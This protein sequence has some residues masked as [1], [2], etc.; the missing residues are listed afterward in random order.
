MTKRVHTL[1]IVLIKPMGRL[2]AR[3]EGSSFLCKRVVRDSFHVVGV[4]PVSQK[5]RKRCRREDLKEAGIRR[6]SSFGMP[7]GPGDL[8]FFR[9]RRTVSKVC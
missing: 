6:I 8:L 4:M 7:S 1:E 5:I 9:R 3:R 2:L